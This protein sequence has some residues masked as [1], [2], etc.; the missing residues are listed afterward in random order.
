[1]AKKKSAKKKEPKKA[2]RSKGK[3]VLAESRDFSVLS[4]AG[5]EQV[6]E[7]Q[8]R[9]AAMVSHEKK[10][11]RFLP[12]SQMH[13]SLIPIDHFYVQL[14]L[15]SKG[16][17]MGSYVNIIGRESAGKS[18]FGYYIL[19]CA[20]RHRNA[21]V[22]ALH[23]DQKPFY[24]DR[25]M[26]AFSSN[27]EHAQLM[28]DNTTVGMVSSFEQMQDYMSAF[29]KEHRVVSK[30]PLEIPIVIMMDNWSKLLTDGEAKGRVDFGKA[31]VDPKAPVKIKEV[32]SGTNLG[33]SKFAS[34]WS[35]HLGAWQRSQNVSI[36]TINDQTEK[37][38]M[39]KVMPG[40]PNPEAMQS[41]LTKSLRNKTH[42]GGRS[43]HQHANLE[44]I[45][46]V[47]SSDVKGDGGAVRGKTIWF[48]NAKSDF[49]ADG[50]VVSME[51]RRDHTQFDRPGYL[52]PA[53][54]MDEGLATYLLE[55]KYYGL[56][57]NRKRFTSLELEV[58]NGTALDVSCAFHKDPI[59]LMTLG[60][61]LQMRGYGDS[62]ENLMITG[63][64][65]G[66]PTIWSKEDE[67]DVEAEELEDSE[68]NFD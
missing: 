54:H 50:Y 9:L 7:V 57:L 33:H 63:E 2:A 20:M 10:P 39:Q 66:D 4:K 16:I 26:R 19:G 29:V 45:M 56:T 24:P 6:R 64:Q 27:P 46:D 60:R 3:K 18:T 59:K 38:N 34:D 55:N 12:L 21:R 5:G 28:M 36:I 48:R 52:D 65:L 15:K 37:I 14:L 68:E 47:G 35:R 13:Q 58:M 22:L 1:M 23:W 53:W 61:E 67:P 51:L 32:G 43:L 17:P 42:R 41:D 31:R 8:T 40:R 44:L 49:S 11:M 25:A 30:L 62:I